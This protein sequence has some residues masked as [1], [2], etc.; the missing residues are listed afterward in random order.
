MKKNKGSTDS[1]IVMKFG[2][3]SVR[4]EESRAHAIKH[5]SSHADSGKQVV[6]VVSQWDVKGS[7]MQPIL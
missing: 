7:L 6:V 1:I 2:G 3:T 5:I 4:S